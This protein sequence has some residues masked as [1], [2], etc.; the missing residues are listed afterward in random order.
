MQSHQAAGVE[1]STTG[2]A[3]PSASSPA[4]SSPGRFGRALAWLAEHPGETFVAGAFA[5]LLAVIVAA[6]APKLG[7]GVGWIA[8]LILYAGYILFARQR[9][10]R[11]RA[12]AIVFAVMLVLVSVALVIAR[13]FWPGLFILL[14]FVGAPA[15][16]IWIARP[17]AAV[18]SSPAA[19]A[20]PRPSVPRRVLAWWLEHPWWTFWGGVF[21]L[22]A[23]SEHSDS[24]YARAIF[25]PTLALM[26]ASYVQGVRLSFATS[27]AI[28]VLIVA[29]AA[30]LTAVPSLADARWGSAA[31]AVLLTVGGP[32]IAEA[33]VRRTRPP[34]K[35]PTVVRTASDRMA[36]A[37]RVFAV[38]AVLALFIWFVTEPQRNARS[39]VRSIRPGMTLGE[40][41]AAT[42][43]R[44][45]ANGH[46]GE[47]EENEPAPPELSV[48]RA[49]RGRF[50]LSFGD[51]SYGGF[52]AEA[53][54]EF[55]VSHPE[56]QTPPKLHLIFLGMSPAK[57]Y[58]Q[59][60]FDSEGRVTRVSGVGAF[61]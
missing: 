44:L 39:T 33:L 20:G 38:F 10:Q 25:W 1:G 47:F 9:W 3:A 34:G 18:A 11:S 50:A 40:A 4:P 56:I 30:G 24:P 12:S 28:G 2:P 31:L 6:Q 27:R 17:R 7:A 45:L 35:R 8:G 60:D 26:Y 58:V 43:G 53:L 61:D 13:S 15:V 46:V 48:S 37:T 42:R 52:T 51:Q 59:I 5:G 16:L 55:L 49:A 32:V 54:A 19:P 29:L 41:L 23:L 22:G 57:A 21:L 36:L 14:A